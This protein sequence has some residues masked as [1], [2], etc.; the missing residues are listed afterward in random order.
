MFSKPF[1]KP[2]Y[3]QKLERLE[4]RIPTHPAL[5]EELIRHNAGFRGEKSLFYFLRELPP[6]HSIILH[7]LRLPSSSTQYFQMDFLLLTEHFLLIFEVKDYAGSIQLNETKRVL[8]R[9]GKSLPNPVHQVARQRHHLTQ[10]LMK[11]GIPPVPIESTIVFSN[12][13]VHTDLPIQFIYP[14][15]LHTFLA[16]LENT[17]SEPILS[18]QIL[19]QLSKILISS[20]VDPFDNPVKKFHLDKNDIQDGVHCPICRH[21]PMVRLRRK[22]SCSKCGRQSSTDYTETLRDYFWLID[23]TISATECAQF[24]QVNSVHTAYRLLKKMDLLSIGGDRNRR[25]DLSSYNWP[26]FFK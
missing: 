13:T 6:H 15:E 16:Q 17:H 11:N 25:Y 23:S 9:D 1:R 22:W 3:L 10:F 14:Y 12:D 18:K 20:H 19:H 7:D 8:E 4:G 5:R 26:H 21:S 24:L 2:L